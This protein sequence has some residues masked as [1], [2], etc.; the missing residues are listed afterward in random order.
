M[1][2]LN[3]TVSA[4]LD[5]VRTSHLGLVKGWL[6]RQFLNLDCLSNSSSLD[7]SLKS[8]FN[9]KIERSC[10]VASSSHIHVHSPVNDPYTIT[11]LVSPTY[12]GINIFDAADGE[13][14]TAVNL[15]E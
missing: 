9:Q 1:I 12:S 15:L 5:P 6:S 7:W 3:M 11:P 13:T 10:L 14:L 4:V 2:Q 8:L